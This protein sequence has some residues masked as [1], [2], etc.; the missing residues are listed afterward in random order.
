MNTP[1]TIALAGKGG[2]GKTSLSAL[3]IKTLQEQGKGPI[4]AVDA[5]PNS[6]LSEI[7]GVTV[8]QTIGDLREDTLDNISELPPSLSKSSY[9]EL[10]LEE[11]LVEEK[12]FDMLVMGHG[13]GPR[14]YCMVN[15]IL[16][17]YIEVLRKNYRYVIIDNEAGMEHL[18]RRTTQNVD[19][20]FIITH[21]EPISIRSAS[22]IYQL[23][24]KLKLHVKKPYLVINKVG[25]NLSSALKDEIANTGLPLFGEIP[26][27]EELVH[28][29]LEGK[30]IWELSSQS[31]AQLAVKKFI[32]TCEKDMSQQYHSFPRQSS[33]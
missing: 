31:K 12:D 26:E 13:E 27:D 11:C 22:R 10:G 6:T 16:R 1:F 18:S 8:H 23:V 30:P 25:G 17:K 20:L 9:L 4:L 29:A 15:H 7:L 33:G 24:K 21:P 2:T 28:L 19:I 32:H 14:C 3:I 5:D